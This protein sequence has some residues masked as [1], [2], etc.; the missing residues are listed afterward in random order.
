MSSTLK[1]NLSNLYCLRIETQEK[2]RQLAELERGMEKRTMGKIMK[3]SDNDVEKLST[4]ELK[5]AIDELR[6]E[7]SHS[8]CRCTKEL[9]KIER[10]LEEID[11]SFIRTILM[12]RYVNLYSW[13]QIAMKIGGGNTAGSIRMAHNR[14]LEK[15]D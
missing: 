10:F 5:K 14:F 13:T 15:C 4:D 7:L 9:T 6:R 3:I 8:L 2:A 11:D 12:L 1:Q